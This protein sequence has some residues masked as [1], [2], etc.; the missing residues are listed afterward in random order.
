MTSES[1]RRRTSPAEPTRLRGVGIDVADSSRVALMV[2]KYGDRFTTR[3]F[4]AAEITHCSRADRPA[5]AYAV[6]FAAKEAVWKALALDWAGPL[7]W[8][9]IEIHWPDGA[10]PQVRLSGEV[11]RCAD[12]ARI[13][14]IVLSSSAA[15]GVVMV[16][17]IAAITS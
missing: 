13:G 7:P 2:S 15:G 8:R 10:P 14:P 12:L 9:F 16:V 11:A 6:R 17:A 5:D 4:T 1:L 3:W